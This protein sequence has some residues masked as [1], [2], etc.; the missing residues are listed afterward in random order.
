MDNVSTVIPTQSI[1]DLY[2]EAGQWHVNVGEKKIHPKRMP[3]K[4]RT[5]KWWASSTWL[6]FFL[7]P[8]VR[9][10][11][12]QAVLFDLPEQKFH[13][14]GLTILPQDLWILAL[15]LLFFAIGLA[16]VTAVAGRVFCGYF[17]FQ[18]VWTDIYVW[19]EERLEGAPRQRQKLDS[20]PWTLKKLRIKVI[21][22]GLWLLIGLI[23]GISFTAWFMDAF[24]LWQGLINLSVPIE[25]G[26]TIGAFIFGTY[27]LAGFMREQTCLWL[28]PYSRIQGV[29]VDS[30][31]V[32]PVY[33][34][35]RGEP[36]GRLQKKTNIITGSARS[37]G[38]CIDCNLCVAVCPTGVDIRQGQQQ[39]CITCGLC[40]DACDAVMDKIGRPQGLI[41]YDS[42]NGLQGILEPVWYKRSRVWT[43]LGIMVFS[44]LAGTYGLATLSPLELKVIQNRQPLFVLQSDGSIQNR[45]QL[46]VLNKTD[47]PTMA[48]ITVEG[49]EGQPLP[50]LVLKGADQPIEIK[51][52][53][54]T[55]HTLFVGLPRHLFNDETT[56]LLFKVQSRKN[57]QLFAEREGVFIGPVSRK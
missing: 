54:V 9:W 57:A 27:S 17:C 55:S 7:G 31:T 21:K 19:I 35:D 1:D 52:S 48:V 34:V 23:T 5:L 18:T 47:Q 10:G 36:R 14:F 42:L 25:A 3:G 32:L 12:R 38:D 44:V 56:Q 8:Y 49:A 40:L 20:G 50:G 28:C 22:H 43:Y 6:V 51:P 13:I 24:E 11:E 4:W 2:A 33:D 26:I 30:N 16:V 29:M 15:I 53:G 39:G 37:E 46:K 45:Y 41:R